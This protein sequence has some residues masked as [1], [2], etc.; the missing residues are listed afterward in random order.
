MP[1][2]EIDDLIPKNIPVYRW[3]MAG[4]T[5]GAMPSGTGQR[6]TLGGLTDQA[7]GTIPLLE[8]GRDATWPWETRA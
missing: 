2:T 8:A 4:Y 3:N 6:H 7:F 5:A 1:E